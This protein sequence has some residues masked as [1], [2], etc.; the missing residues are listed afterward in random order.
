MR[1]IS[2]NSEK[3]QVIHNCVSSSFRHEIRPFN[4]EC[5]RILQIGTDPNKNID[6]VAAALTGV[7]CHLVVIGR[8]SSDQRS[9]IEE[10]GVS[11]ENHFG[12]SDDSIVDQY[13]MCDLVL[14]ASTYE[15]FGLPIIEANAVGRAVVTSTVSSMP[16][17]AG[18]AA[19][20]V[21]P[22]DVASIRLGVIK[23]IEN[24]QYRDS[25]V[26]A[27]LSNVRRFRGSVIAER[28]ADL[29]RAVW[30]LKGGG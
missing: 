11:W 7:K 29:Y 4:S 27:G 9:A 13:V 1:H 22:F 12:L 23:V 3:I 26:K 10:S 14:F 15:G 28:Y 19:C 25:L 6:R 24:V 20:L 2:C 30:S 5:P 18:D 21:D 8:L 17:V 16:E